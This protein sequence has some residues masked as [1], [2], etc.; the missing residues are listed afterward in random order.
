MAELLEGVK[1]FFRELNNDQYEYAASDD[2]Q[3]YEIP[4]ASANAGKA[5]KKERSRYNPD[6]GADRG[7]SF[8]SRG[9]V[10]EMFDKDPPKM[11]KFRP[12]SYSSNQEAQIIG[13][14][15]CSG[16]CVLL[17][18]ESINSKDARRLL[19][20]IAGVTFSLRGVT[21]LVS[22]NVYFFGPEGTDY[23]DNDDT[24]TT[25]EDYE[26]SIWGEE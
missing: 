8:G 14:A 4:K 5:A 18:L 17:N 24:D 2:A 23:F 20:F 11:S 21:K 13:N 15:I 12:R 10:I 16:R 7:N 6:A 22:A 19:D 9:E 3:N 1:D 25:S 26:N